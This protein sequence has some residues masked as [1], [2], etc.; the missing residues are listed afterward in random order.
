M[1]VMVIMKADAASESGDMTGA[2]EMFTAMGNYN[3]ALIEAGIMLSG[4][5]LLPSSKGA[6]VRFADGKTT[7]IDGPFAEAKELIA[8]FW[9]WKVD[10][11]AHAIEWVRRCPASAGEAEI[12]VRQ[13][14]EMEDFGDEFTPELQAQEERQRAQLEAKT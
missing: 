13:I 11:L 9:I 4:E 5:G 6:R 12:E 14:A 3:D 7:V 10:S 8:G 1:R 2:E